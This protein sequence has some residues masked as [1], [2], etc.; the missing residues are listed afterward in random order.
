MVT[1]LYILV[2]FLSNRKDQSG[3]DTGKVK[4]S[5]SNLTQEM[6]DD[7]YEYLG[8]YFYSLYNKGEK[9][10]NHYTARNEHYLAEFK[11]I[12][13]KQDLDKMLGIQG[14]YAPGCNVH[15]SPLGG[16]NFEYFSEDGVQAGIFCAYSVKGAT[17]NGDDFV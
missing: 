16:R 10:R 5:I 9:I 14:W 3:D 7:G 17:E 8:D 6:H 1:L 13:E 4:E 2:S 11:A 12:C 15:R